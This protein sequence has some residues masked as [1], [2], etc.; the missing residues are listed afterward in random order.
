M[1]CPFS[2]LASNLQVSGKYRVESATDGTRI[3][4]INNFANRAELNRAIRHLHESQVGASI[5][6]AAFDR[7]RRYENQWLAA[8]TLR[9]RIRIRNIRVCS[10]QPDQR[11]YGTNSPKV[12]R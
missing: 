6:T 1:L 4:R 12:S 3:S 10:M 2:I 8:S 11:C 5:C 9:R 7:T